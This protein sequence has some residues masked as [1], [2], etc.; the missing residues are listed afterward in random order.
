MAEKNEDLIFGM[1]L[2]VDPGKFGQQWP[3]IEADLQKI[4]DAHPLKVGIQID[5]AALQNAITLLSKLST[6]SGAPKQ[7]TQAAMLIANK[8]AEILAENQAIRARQQNI[9]ETNKLRISNANAEK[10]ELALERAKQRG[11]AAVHTQNK[12]YQS[13]RGLLNGMPQMMNSYISVLGAYRLGKNIIATTAEF[14][15]QRVALAAIIQNKTKADELFAQSVEMGIESPFLIKDI[16]TY[17]KQLAAYRIETDKLFDTTKRLADISAGLGVG[18]DRLILA[19]GQVKAASVLRGQELRQFTEAGIPLVELLAEK[20]TKL[21]GKMTTTADVFDLIRAR[22]VSFEM[23][24]EIFEDMTNEGGMFNN[25]QAIQAQTLKGSMS[26]LRDAMDKTFMQMGDGAKGPIKDLVDGLRYL[27]ENWRAVSDVVTTGVAIWGTAKLASIAYNK[28]IGQETASIIANTMAEKRQEAVR[29]QRLGATRALTVTEQ[30]YIA[31]SRKMTMAD[32][33]SLAAKGQL[34]PLMLMQAVATKR[35]TVKQGELLGATIGVSSAEIAQAASKKKLIVYTN[36]FTAALKVQLVALRTTMAALLSNPFTWIVVAAAGI[37]KL[38][39][40]IRKYNKEYTD[41]AADMRKQ[42]TALA[43]SMTDSYKKMSKDIEAA[44]GK[45]ASEQA[46]LSTRKSMQDILEKNELIGDLLA[47]RLSGLLTEKE[48][49]EAVRDMWNEVHAAAKDDPGYMSTAQKGTGG[50]MNDDVVE[51]AENVA[52]KLNEINSYLA[53]TSAKGFNV[54]GVRK[55]FDRLRE[56]F[57]A[58]SLSINQFSSALLGMMIDN[59][60]SLDGKVF[61][62]LNRKVKDTRS[63]LLGFEYDMTSM[64]KV[65][66]AQMGEIDGK[67]PVFDVDKFGLSDKSLGKLHS[68]LATQTNFWLQ[69]LGD[70]DAGAKRL[71]RT[72]MKLRSQFPFTKPVD[73]ENPYAKS[74]NDFLEKK[75]LNKVSPMDLKDMEKSDATQLK[76]VSDALEEARANLKRYKNELRAGNDINMDKIAP[77][78]EDIRQLE[79]AFAW[80]GGSEDEKAKKENP[81]ISK[82]KEQIKV[83]KDAYKEY[84]ELRQWMSEEDAKS[85]VQSMY[86]GMDTSMFGLV[87]SD[88][89]LEKVLGDASKKLGKISKKDAQDLALDAAD[90]GFDALKKSVQTNLDKLARD[91]EQAQEANDFF[92]TI[93]GLTGSEDAARRMTE[94]MGLAVGDIRTQL[95]SA[96]GAVMKAGGYTG[97]IN[98]G[99]IGGM[100]EMVDKL[101]ENYR[102]AAKERLDA[103]IEYEKKEAKA[104]MDGLEDF[105]TADQRKLLVM[106]NTAKKIQSIQDS[107]IPE[108]MKADLIKAWRNKG[109]AEIA[110]IDFEELKKMKQYVQAFEDLDRVGDTTLMMLRGELEK[111]A[112]SGKLSAT[113]MKT[114]ADQIQKIDDLL[115]GRHP[116]TSMIDGLNEYRSAMAEVSKIG[117][118]YAD[119]SKE[120]AEAQTKLRAAIDK[121]QKAA[122]NLKADFDEAA[123]A[124]NSVINFS[125][126]LADTLGVSFSDETQ[127]YIDSFTGGIEVA[128]SALSVMTAVTLALDAA[129]W[130]LLAVAAAVG[131]AFVGIT[132]ITNAVNAKTERDIKNNANAIDELAKSLSR[133]SDETS[134]KVGS[135]YVKNIHDQIAANEEIIRLEEKQI[136]N[137]KKLSKTEA[138]PWWLLGGIATYGVAY[139]AAAKKVKEAE[140]SIAKSEEDIIARKKEIL[141]LERSLMQEATGYDSAASAARAFADAWYQAYLSSENTFDLIGEKFKEMID[142]MIVQSILAEAVAAKLA[143]VFDKIREAYDDG[144]MTPE[145]LAGIQKMAAN[146]TVGMDSELKNLV[147]GLQRS[148]VEVRP[149]SKSLSGISASV[150]SMSE[151]TAKTLGGYL[152][153]GLRQWVLQTGFQGRIAVGVESVQK[154]LLDIYAMQGQSLAAINSI[155][156]D[157]AIMVSKLTR[158]VDNQDSTLISGGQK[159]VNVRLIN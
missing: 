120:A 122:K 158:L 83:V 145:E 72:Q 98:F 45:G 57:D 97:E 34:T 125:E 16:I 38:V 46:M 56:E 43:G 47:A 135:A 28:A 52:K 146:V 36:L 71:L 150:S 121:T 40:S 86:G 139:L 74:Y 132:A 78:I 148:G 3:K 143:P 9:I 102:K 105:M 61:D 157:T 109:D 82:I 50:F 107:S 2:D 106:K 19:Y 68:S 14:E 11:I 95:Q 116:F 141:E 81:L 4:I 41:T 7:S 54:S 59:K 149:T 20:F 21:N 8:K 69:S 115:E 117:E 104:L 58:G 63:A 80:L 114:V 25:M 67:M 136:E 100:Q 5:N 42:S 12:A 39:S 53:K 90:A 152:N 101:P 85:K 144:I 66:I 62:Q 112:A 113:Q 140:D 49:L 155:K 73:D 51:N 94:A 138:S 128:T 15:M 156:S 84:T 29:L 130:P 103:I 31:T 127:E 33:R 6:L 89:D 137:N 18:M 124:I 75:G 91:I 76:V 37:T 87:F 96:L 99:D 118:V 60:G 133:L 23:V 24:K 55:E 27:M 44:F 32:W 142:T 88:E 13:Q 147:I 151:D 22:G 108:T 134:G 79:I 30:L 159:A 17:T 111:L 119:N 131:V 93:L 10:S 64:A 48:R 110:G 126:T 153:S 65:T 154:P 1:K 92:E 70:I 77:S 26:N 129:L 123:G 35:L